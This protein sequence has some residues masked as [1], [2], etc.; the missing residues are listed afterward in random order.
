VVLTDETNNKNTTIPVDVLILAM[1]REPGTNLEQLN[2]Q[3]AGVKWTK[4]DGVTV[5]SD[6]RSVSAK[7][8]YA[9]G[10]CA[11]AVQNRDRRS[12]HAGWTGYHAVQSALL[13]RVFRPA[14]GVHP[15]VPRVIYT[16]PEIASIG[17][18]YVDCIRTYGTRG[19]RVMREYEK[20]TDR[21]DTDSLERDTTVGFVE[22][23]VSHLHG[24]LLGATVVSPAAS[25]S[26]NEIGVALVNGLSCRDIA[27]SLHSYP[28]HGYLMYR[29]SLALTLSDIWGLLS[30]CGPLGRAA[31][32]VGGTASYVLKSGR[33]KQPRWWWRKYKRNYREW[34][35]K[36]ADYEFMN[37]PK[38]KAMVNYTSSTNKEQE[39]EENH[40][41]AYSMCTVC[42]YVG[43]RCETLLPKQTNTQN[44]KRAR[45]RQSLLSFII[46][47]DG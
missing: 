45:M 34:E 24:R 9:A 7:H 43:R 46:I 28:S 21:A 17:L 44:I 30:A 20:H 5:R 1:G 37:L 36:G 14:S 18:S 40:R 13:P 22:L 41:R 10:D 27:R 19:F 23:R 4:K 11:S 8:V 47:N 39:A 33:G 25:E 3:K 2:L 12:V 26:I 6:L 31:S 29:V 38:A 35:T 16:N 42:W 15:Y 32:V